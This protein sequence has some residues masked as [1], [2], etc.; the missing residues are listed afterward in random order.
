[1]YQRPFVEPIRCTA[2]DLELEPSHVSV[3]SSFS[4]HPSSYLV[5][6]E[7]QSGFYATLTTWSFHTFLLPDVL[8]FGKRLQVCGFACS[9]V[10]ESVFTPDSPKLLSSTFDGS[11]LDLVRGLF[12][13]EYTP[14]F[15]KSNLLPLQN[16]ISLFADYCRDLFS[17]SDISIHGCLMALRFD[18]P[19]DC[20]NASSVLY[21]HNVLHNLTPP[22]SIR[23]RFPYN[24]SSSDITDFIK[25]F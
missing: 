20:L 18:N 14:S 24:L 9:D 17:P 6:D 11:P 25:L 19:S 8:I 15:I 2:G 13:L 10:L 23:F 22:A 7:I 4:N 21:R 1:M 16:N 12:L 5:Y 3:I